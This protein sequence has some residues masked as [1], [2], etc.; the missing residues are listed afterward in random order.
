MAGFHSLA[1]VVLVTQDIGC[2]VWSSE[3]PPLSQKYGLLSC[4]CDHCMIGAWEA[5]V[6]MHKPL[7]GKSQ[8]NAPSLVSLEIWVLA[9]AAS[10]PA[11]EG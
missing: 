3:E 8:G 1:C 7:E 6:E 2:V 9:L 5:E 4:N 11:C 10:L